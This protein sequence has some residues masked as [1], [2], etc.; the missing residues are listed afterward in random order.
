MPESTRDCFPSAA[1]VV[2]R[3]GGLGP[4]QSLVG[5]LAQVFRD[6][7]LLD[8]AQGIATRETGKRH[9]RG[10]DEPVG[11]RLNS[12]AVIWRA[13]T[14]P[15]VREI[16]VLRAVIEFI[17]RTQFAADVETHSSNSYNSN[18]SPANNPHGRALFL[19]GSFLSET[20][21]TIHVHH[22]EIIT[23]LG[24]I[25]VVTMEDTKELFHLL[26]LMQKSHLPEVGQEAGLNGIGRQLTQMFLGKAK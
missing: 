23:Q 5:R 18:R 24:G 13:D 26:N 4:A 17:T 16:V 21:V 19:G 22:A 25:H 14:I 9:R 3:S 8:K 11:E 15:G 2:T 10:G 20:V 6:Y 12:G 1:L 7:S